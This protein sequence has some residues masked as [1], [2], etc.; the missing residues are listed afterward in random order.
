MPIVRLFRLFC[1]VLLAV[2]VLQRVPAGAG[3]PDDFQTAVEDAS[4]R[5]RLALRILETEGQRE[6]AAA[7]HSF[8]QSWQRVVERYG[9]IR[10]AAATDDTA[11][12]LDVDMRIVGVLLVIDLGN[13]DAART[14]LEAIESKVTELSARSSPPER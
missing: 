11:M 10:P 8:R 14:G 1:A 6:T 5:C 2:L 4:A 9:A 12:F 13:R 3:E 7:V